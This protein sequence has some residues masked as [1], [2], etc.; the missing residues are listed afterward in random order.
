M[1][2]SRRGRRRDDGFSLIEIVVTMGLIATVLTASMPMFVSM[3][4]ATLTTKMQTQAK[5]LAQERLEHVRDL[6]FHVAR[7]NGQFLDVLDMYYTNAYTAGTVTTVSSGGQALTGRYVSTGGGTNGEPAAPYYRVETGQLAGAPRFRQ[8]ITTQFLTAGGAGV[9]PATGVA[10]VYDSQ[11]V[12]RDVPPTLMLGV[13]VI[14][15]WTE[16]GRAKSYRTY[17][18]VTES[19]PEQPLIQSQA[20][21]VAVDLSSTSAESKTLRLQGGLTTLDGGQSSGS[22][23]SGLAS[24]AVASETGS[25]PVEGSTARF[26]YPSDGVT[27]TGSSSPSDLCMWYGFGNT[28][29]DNATGSITDGLPRAPQGI[30]TDPTKRVSA[31]LNA[32]GNMACPLMQFHNVTSGAVMRSDA[33]GVAL[34]ASPFAVMQDGSAASGA[35][36]S[37]AYVTATPLTATPQQT[38]AGAGASMDRS[39]RLFPNAPDAAGVGLVTARL[40]DARVGCVS[41]TPSTAGTVSATYELRLR[42][43]GS[44][45]PTGTVGWH[46]GTYTYNSSTNTAPV[47]TGAAWNPSAY[48]LT[49]GRP[50]SDVVFGDAP[51]AV[52]AGTTTGARGFPNGILTLTTAS[53]LANEPV[54]GSSAVKLQL[55]QLSCVADDQR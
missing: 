32:T 44:T 9:L 26:L 19:R 43:R 46:E 31:R 52:T 14:T 1:S 12:G 27:T 20:R 54:A 2:T 40:V 4:R 22:F 28:G 10:N 23:V 42:W 50:L 16:A 3:L 8:V 49:G 51:G 33:L 36:R 17:T 41:G 55:G 24:G 30:E 34:G 38:S 6:R 37:R 47:L 18:Q 45:T 5:N 25:A 29:V 39:V 13:T 53:T 7:Q 35:V 11:V 48:Y 21:A 15:K